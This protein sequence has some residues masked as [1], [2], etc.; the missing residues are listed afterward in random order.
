M[1]LPV[2]HFKSKALATAARS[3]PVPLETWKMRP[4]SAPKA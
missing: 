2:N 3:G 4:A 1:N